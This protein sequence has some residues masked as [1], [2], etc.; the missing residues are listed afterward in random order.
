[1]RTLSVF[2]L[3]M[4]LGAY[5]WVSRLGMLFAPPF[6]FVFLFLSERV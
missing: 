5:R 6:D 4:P 3:Q 2:P 1:M